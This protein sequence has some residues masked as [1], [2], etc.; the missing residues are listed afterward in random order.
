MNTTA[1]RLAFAS[2]VI[3]SA[4]FVFITSAQLP[5][6]VASQFGSGGKVTN[7]MP[8]DAYQAFM[9]GMTFLIPL[10]LVVFQVW[11][12]RI[13]TRFVSIPRRD[14]WLATPER[15][16]QMLDYLERHALISGLAPPLFFAGIHWLV[17]DANSRVPPLLN[18]TLF[19][20]IAGLFVVWVIAAA[21]TLSLRF[22][23]DA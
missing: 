19:L 4:L 22:R 23:R 6:P 17:A 2:I 7:H 12:P 21:V 10:V 18:N 20:A 15:R 9:T 3:A 14:Y 8:R 1:L 16:A 5:D 11:L 13:V